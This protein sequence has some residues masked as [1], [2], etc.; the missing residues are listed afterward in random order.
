MSRW[1]QDLNSEQK[2]AVSTT[3]GPLLVLAGAGSGKTRVITHRVAHLIDHGAAPG[4]ILGVT[5]TNKAAGEMRDRLRAMVGARAD[6]IVLSTF[7]AFGLWF[8]REEAQRRRRRSRF[9]IF[10]VG[11]QLA[12]LRDLARQLRLERSFDLGSLLTRISA[13]KNAF[14]ARDAPPTDSEDPY[15]EAAALLYPRY[16][17]QL[18]AF[19]FAN[20]WFLPALLLVP[21]GFGVFLQHR[22]SKTMQEWDS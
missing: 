13:Y 4:Q 22:F 10:D 1:L 16:C 8:L 9:T 15:D 3:E 14:V 17:E 12:L 20:Q 18:E 21:M 5:F 11:D 2:R 6:E 7:H 19:V